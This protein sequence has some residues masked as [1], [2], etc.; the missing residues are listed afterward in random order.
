MPS[1]PGVTFLLRTLPHLLVAPGVVF[2]LDLLRRQFLDLDIPNWIL[3]P[4]YLLSWPLQLF[5]IV[6]RRDILRGL[7]ARRRGARPPPAIKHTSL[8]NYKVVSYFEETKANGYLGVSIQGFLTF[9]FHSI[10]NPQV[11]RSTNGFRN[12]EILSMP[13][14]SLRIE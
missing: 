5:I 3:I 9:I 11:K 6:Q 10:L 7:E 12:V 4:V 2:A 13:G 8:G 1:R 14:S